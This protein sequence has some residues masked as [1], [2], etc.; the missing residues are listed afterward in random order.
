M[1]SI[2]VADKNAIVSRLSVWIQD[3]EPD[4]TESIEELYGLLTGEA[5]AGLISSLC[6]TNPV[7]K[8]DAKY[9]IVF[10]LVVLQASPVVWRARLRCY[11]GDS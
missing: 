1:E 8:L 6:H 7:L 9:L 10:G 3:S 11:R 4:L 2:E 5:Y